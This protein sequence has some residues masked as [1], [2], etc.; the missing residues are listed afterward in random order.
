MRMDFWNNPLVVKA[1]RVKY[2][3][4]S[5]FNNTSI[6]LV[7]L[8]AGGALLHYYN[9]R[10]G[11]P[12]PRNFLLGIFG[13]QF[14][15]SSILAA[16]ATSTSM[17]SEVMH[18]TLDFQRIASLSPRQLVWGKL[19]GESAMAYLLGIATVPLTVWC[20]ILGVAGVPLPIL[21]LLYVHLFTTTMLFGCLGLLQR[22]EVAPG[23]LPGHGVSGAGWAIGALI[24]IPQLLAGSGAVLAYPWSRTLVGLFTPVPLFYGI[25]RGDLFGT[26][27]TFPFFGV[28]VPFLFA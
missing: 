19:L 4:G 13:I 7:L 11:G 12:W 20:C 17:R 28:D 15:I 25:A 2:R 16:S 9:D 8:V 3:R 6:Y 22:L 27:M 14:A 18:R 23:R 24:F 5:I 1:F 21:A 10:F 26:Y